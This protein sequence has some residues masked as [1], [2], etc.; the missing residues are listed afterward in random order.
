MVTVIADKEEL[1]TPVNNGVTDGS[2]GHERSLQYI[3]DYQEVSFKDFSSSIKIH[4]IKGG[5]SSVKFL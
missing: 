4:F 1:P 2:N 5:F 3:K